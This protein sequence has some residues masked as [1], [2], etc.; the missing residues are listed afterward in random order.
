[1]IRT[2]DGD[3]R[4]IQLEATPVADFYHQTMQAL[5]ELGLQTRIQA[6]PDEVE[7]AIPF[8]EDTEHADYDPDAVQLA[9]LL[10]DGF[11][12]HSAAAYYSQDNGQ[13]LLPYEDVRTADDP[14]R[15]LQ[16]FVHTAYEAVA[17]R[18]VWDR[19]ALEDDP[20]RWDQH[21]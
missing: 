14:D 18:G 19:A 3:T 15:A 11:G 6:R 1:V 20:T 4:R 5:D 17:E 16:Q 8:A 12:L 10:G 13:F 21:R 7:Q 2:S 9:L